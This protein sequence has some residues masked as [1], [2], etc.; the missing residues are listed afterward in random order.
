MSSYVELHCHSCY[1]FLDGASSPGELVQRAAALG[2]PALAVTDHNGLY[3]A[4]EFCRAAREAGVHPIIGAEVTLSNGAHLTLLAEDQRGYSNLCRLI[5]RA[6]LAGQKNA[7][8]LTWERLRAHAEGLICLSGC[9]QG[10]VARAI[11]KKDCRRAMQVAETLREVFGP[12]HFYIELQRHL[13]PDDGRLTN[14]LTRL[15]AHLGVGIVATNN[16]HHATP[17]A[18]PLHDVLTCIRHHTTLELG[19]SWLWP[20]GERYLKSSAQI[21]D[22]FADFPEAIRNTQRIAERCAV[23]LNLSAYRLPDFPVPGGETPFSTLYRLCQEGAR[24]RYRPVTPAVSRQ[25]AHELDVIQRTGLATFF[26]VVWDICRFCREQGIPCQGRG[27]A[28][29]SLVAYVLGITAVDPLAHDLLFERFLSEEGNTTPDIDLDISTAHRDRVIEYVYQ[30]YGQEHTAMA[31]NV[32][33]FRAR[34]AVRDVGKVLGFPPDVVNQMAQAIRSANGRQNGVLHAIDHHT[35]APLEDQLASAEPFRSQVRSSWETFVKLVRA[36][37]GVPR[38]LSIH[39]GGMLITACPL[40]D[41]VPLERATM[42]GRVV[43]QWNKDS[44]EDAGLIKVDLLG[45]RTL[46]LIH[47]A[48]ALI[49]EHNEIEVDIQALPLDDPKVYDLLCAADTIGAFQVESRAQAQLLPRLKPRR[50][51]DLVVSV[52]IIR[53]GPIQGN[54]VHPFLRRREGLERVEYLHPSLEPVLAET[55]GVMLYQEQVL[56]VAVAVAGFTPGQADALRRAMS[57]ARSREAIEALRP[58]FI[59][60]AQARGVDPDVAETIFDQIAGYA[61]YGFCKSHAASFALIAYTTC[62]LK[63]YYPAAFYC[64][65]LNNQP[66][67][68]YPVEVVVNDARRHGVPVLRP[69]IHRSRTP[70]VLEPRALSDCEGQSPRFGIRLGFRF[71]KGVGDAGGERIEA[72]RM[73]GAFQDLHDFC[74]RTR[75]PRRVVERLILVAAMDD[76]ALPRRKLLWELGRI[77]VEEDLELELSPD[78]IELPALTR[79]E[80]VQLEYGTLD[81]NVGEQV[82]ALYRDRLAAD[83]V[84]SSRDLAS[85]AEGTRVRVA[86]LQVIRQRPGTAKGMVFASL[87][88]EWGLINVV[89]PPAI[90]ERYRQ[91]WRRYRLLLVTGVVERQHGVVQVSASELSP[92][93]ASSSASLGCLDSHHRWFP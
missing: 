21:A 4:V 41:I 67:G 20:N 93:P 2:M 66:M 90:Y 84:L 51:E 54:M 27:S 14:L 19:R 88:D 92:L 8:V 55:L 57:R 58:K 25:L 91:V 3:G 32:V 31:C 85:A 13:L 76:W 11:L 46:S 40:I 33:T 68:F 39:N 74:R 29:N 52:A 77:H 75:L 59:Q 79:E 30:T 89:V 35:D 1:S 61:G 70:C 18:Q 56:K 9:R 82:M 63:V 81:L 44:I 65:L 16:V 17:E 48:V 80:L 64:A 12:D 86:G 50:F 83:G 22:L 62:W 72:A 42:P 78:D 49:R 71:V 38:H 10:P 15:A 60:G 69:D 45:L 43:I 28:A 24:R 23:S 37:I 73:R 5:S 6:Q 26:L 87:E 47:E 36:M 34:S 53:P 7:P